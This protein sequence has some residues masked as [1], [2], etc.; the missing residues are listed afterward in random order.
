MTRESITGRKLYYGVEAE[1]QNK[2]LKAEVAK[3]IRAYVWDGLY[4]RK[5]T[6]EQIECYLIS[7]EKMD[8][9]ESRKL[10]ATVQKKHAKLV[11]G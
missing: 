10:I 9:T 6:P 5:E 7:I 11:K 1:R 3:Q 2:I 8:Q 4:I